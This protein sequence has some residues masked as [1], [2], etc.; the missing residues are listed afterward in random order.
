MSVNNKITIKNINFL[1]GKSHEDTMKQIYA[2]YWPI[3]KANWQIVSLVQF[4][5]VKF[6]PPMVIIDTILYFLDLL[7]IFLF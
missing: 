1:Q 5:N 7:T 4:F 6:V 2:I 3:L